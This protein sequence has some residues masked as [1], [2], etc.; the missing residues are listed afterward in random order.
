MLTK[1]TKSLTMILLAFVM[2][3]TLCLGFSGFS[4]NLKG[5]EAAV[6]TSAD[7]AY[8]PSETVF[9]SDFVGTTTISTT[10][11][12]WSNGIK[13]YANNGAT[14][15]SSTS[16][17]TTSVDYPSV[18]TAQFGSK[19]INQEQTTGL[20]L[21]AFALTIRVKEPCT[22]KINFN[23]NAAT[24]TATTTLS[25]GWDNVDYATAYTSSSF[26]TVATSITTNNYFSIDA[27]SVSVIE[28]EVTQAML[29]SSAT[30]C[31]KIYYGS[32]GTGAG[33]I[34]MFKSVEVIAAQTHEHSYGAPEYTWDGVNCTATMTCA[35]TDG[36]CDAV[37][38]TETKTGTLTS[39]TP[40]TCSATGLEV[41]T[42]TF[43]NAAF[44]AQTTEV[45]L[46]IDPNAHQFSDPVVTKEP[47]CSETG[48]Q[49]GTCDLC[50]A[51][52]E[53]VLD[54]LPHT[55][56][57][58]EAVAPTCSETGLTEGK[59]CSVCNEVTVPQTVVP[60]T[61]L[62]TW[63]DVEGSNTATCTEAG[64]KDQRCSV[65]GETQ[66]V[67]A[68][69]LGH[70]IVD[71]ECTVCGSMVGNVNWSYVESG[72]NTPWN[73]ATSTA[74]ITE[75]WILKNVNGIQII[76]KA[77]KAYA[78]IGSSNA[79]AVQYVKS[80]M[81]ENVIE[82]VI[83][84]G[85]TAKVTIEASCFNSSS[86][87]RAVALTMN[88]QTISCPLDYDYK[89]G[90]QYTYVFDGL[91]AGTYG[92][93]T[94]AVGTATTAYFG[95]ISV[96]YVKPISSITLGTIETVYNAQVGDT[97]I[98][99]PAQISYTGDETGNLDIAWNESEIAAALATAGTHTVTGTV[100]APAG[101]RFGGTKLT[102]TISVTVNTIEK[103]HEHVWDGGTVITPSTC[104]TQGVIR[105]TC[106]YTDENGAC[107]ATYDADLPLADHT[108]EVIAGKPATCTETGLTDGARCSVCGEITLEQQVIEALGHDFV[109]DVCTRCGLRQYIHTVNF[110]IFSD[111]N[112]SS[113]IS[114]A[115]TAKFDAVSSATN[116]FEGTYETYGDYLKANGITAYSNV[117]FE[118][119]NGNQFNGIKFANGGYIEFTVK[120]DATVYFYKGKATAL[121]ITGISE[122]FATAGKQ[123]F[124]ATAGTTYRI[125][126]SGAT[127]FISYIIIDD[128]ASELYIADG[129]A[130]E[131]TFIANNNDNFIGWTNGSAMFKAGEAAEKS[132]D[133]KHLV[134]YKAVYATLTADSGAGL[135]LTEDSTNLGLRFTFSLMFNGIDLSALETKEAKDN[136]LATLFT[137]EANTVTMY[138][139]TG[140]GYKAATKNISTV[141]FVENNVIRISVVVIG[142]DRDLDQGTWY[143]SYKYSAKVNV[144][145]CGKDLAADNFDMVGDGY[146]VKEIAQAQAD[147]GNLSEAEK[148][149]YGIA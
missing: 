119:G 55:E 109:D 118:S 123:S 106:T 78:D 12:Y 139:Y 18:T 91:T 47:T 102:E 90:D 149:A 13:F 24:G 56:V 148:T 6:S 38:V 142:I 135:Y 28:Y 60:A 105:Y 110:D 138:A 80:D 35:N 21:Q 112:Q 99:L 108:D 7:D 29:D 104:Q 71:G 133:N 61:G 144:Q 64:T 58:D 69:A 103:T 86:K 14:L 8:A 84:A 113:A 39:M 16:R 145:L 36:A 74:K 115:L 120:N 96:D 3:L 37:T 48:L 4:A 82:I 121:T 23:S 53:Q 136:F 134:V 66:T 130:T 126:A 40:A 50:G 114:K 125:T 9:D 146:T 132:A 92:V 30:D 25:M 107:G 87:K 76:A 43:E 89:I 59:H 67:A 20:V 85:Y 75:D 83:P 137:G 45:V 72:T 33:K 42:A 81:A 88:G 143:D 15:S 111:T 117:S 65:C 11:T 70:N 129:V 31:L 127:E 101:C 93:T 140:E 124:S 131:Q 2:A 141:S 51:T 27:N 41:Y 57:I 77:N 63:E 62:H 19:C 73:G 1:K 79:A 34:F 54:K 17:F 68:P 122:T 10:T 22:V 100:T 128:G 49:T 95:L 52:A 32:S 46:P 44:T 26:K 147:A 98:S 5:V 94:T 97:T 116:Y